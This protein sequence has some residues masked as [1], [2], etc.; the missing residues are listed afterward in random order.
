MKK[1]YNNLR[2]ICMDK[3]K[4]KKQIITQ[5]EQDEITL[6]FK[7]MGDSTRFTIIVALFEAEL[8]VTELTKVTG[9]NQ[10]A[11][12]HQLRVLKEQDIVRFKKQGKKRIYY[13]ADH[14]IK[15]LYE[16]ALAHIREE[17]HES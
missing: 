3:D 9:M 13:L 4:I 2:E 15:T 10:S 7:T 8:S 11:V 5:E 1:E 12:S 17:K 6:L 14:H 16:L